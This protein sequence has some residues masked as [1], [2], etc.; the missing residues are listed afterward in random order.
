ME[1]YHR[2]MVVDKDIYSVAYTYGGP[3]VSGPVDEANTST[4]EQTLNPC[5]RVV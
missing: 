4:D 5:P 1:D 2:L 3:R